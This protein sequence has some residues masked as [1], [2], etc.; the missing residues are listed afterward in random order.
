R[1]QVGERDRDSSDGIDDAVQR[2]RISCL[3]MPGLEVA[4]FG[5]ANTQEDAQDFQACGPLGKL[6]I[7]AGSALLDPREVES[8]RVGYGLQEGAVA[9]VRVRAR[10]CSVLSDSQR[11]NCVAKFV[12]E[13]GVS[14]TTAIARPEIGV[15]RQLRQV[16]KPSE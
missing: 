14:V 6:S 11:G 8:S 2:R 3:V 13:V 1:I 10:D 15:N 4:D 9:H 5:S 16:G 7:E 12:S